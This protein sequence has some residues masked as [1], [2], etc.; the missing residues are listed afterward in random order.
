M[1][2]TWK[3]VLKQGDNVSLLNDDAGYGSNTGDITGVSAGVGLSGGGTSGAVSL[4]LDF[5]ELTDMTGGVSGTTEVILQDSSTESRKAMNEIALSNFSNDSGWT[6]NVGDITGVTA[7]TGMSGGGTSGT[8]TLTN[9]GV[10]SNVAG[11][12][13][14]VSG[15]TGA[16]TVTNSGVTS[17]VAGSNITVSGATG[18]VTIAGTANDAVSNAN[19]LTSLGNLESAGGATDQTI[20]FGLDVGDTISFRGNV[21]VGGNMIV[22][23]TTTTINSTTLA[24]EDKLIKIADVGTPTVTTADGAG[25]QVESSASESTFPE[26]KWYKNKGAGN[27]DGTGTSDGLTGWVIQNHHTSN[28]IELPI[29]TMQFKSGAFSAETS[30]GIGSLGYDT[31][32]QN[33]YIRINDTAP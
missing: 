32:G 9:A 11:T 31:S 19:L 16:V 8:V 20:A 4:A 21:T 26:F 5:S 30:A 13:I 1:P 3:R 25:I 33:L 17:N 24:V 12:G 29:A 7:G 22:N 10:T 18:A 2:V 27:G 15:A 28:T 23:G 6:A 14:S